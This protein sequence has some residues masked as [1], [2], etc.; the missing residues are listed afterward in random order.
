MGVASVVSLLVVNSEVVGSSVVVLVSRLMDRDEPIISSAIKLAVLTVPL[1][2]CSVWSGLSVATVVVVVGVVV[3]E[4]VV[5]V[6]VVVVVLDEVVNGVVTVVVV[7]AVEVVVGA[8][9][10]SSVVLGIVVTSS[11]S[12]VVSK[13]GVVVKV[14]VVVL[15]LNKLLTKT[16]LGKYFSK[17]P[18]LNLAIESMNCRLPTFALN[19][20]LNG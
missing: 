10:T 18:F 20:P 19:K 6:V 5:V 12:E 8:S 4:V 9:V 15:T 13:I 17:K 16:F 14:V 3:L 1:V 2:L 11:L 7:V